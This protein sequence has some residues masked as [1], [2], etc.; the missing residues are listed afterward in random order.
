[1]CWG[2]T[3]SISGDP[4][5]V[6]FQ[7]CPRLHSIYSVPQNSVGPNQVSPSLHSLA[8][9]SAKSGMANTRLDRSKLIT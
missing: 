4:N 1:M 5:H 8:Q 7:L 2:G 6:S 9:V 3:K